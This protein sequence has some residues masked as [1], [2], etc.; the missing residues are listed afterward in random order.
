MNPTAADV[1]AT[2]EYSMDKWQMNQIPWALW[3]CAGGLVICLHADSRGGNGAALAFFYIAL[4]GLAFAGWAGTTLIDRSGYPYYVTLP[5]VIIIAIVIAAFIS[6]FGSNRGYPAYGRLWWSQL[7][8]PPLNVF[9][10]MLLYLGAGWIAFALYRHTY[11]GRPIIMLTPAGI[12]FH[13]AWLQNVFI[14][15]Q[16]VQGVGALEDENPGRAPTIYPH[17]I[18]VSVT[19]DSY[20]NYILPKRSFLSPPGSE[21]MFRPKGPLMQMVLA[22]PELIVDFEDF[23][24][25][26]EAR[27]KAFRDQARADAP[28]E[29]PPGMP[30]IFGRWS[31]DVPWWRAILF[32]MPLLGIAAVVLNAIR[33]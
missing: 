7:V 8:N 25:P 27:W 15:W 28:S 10:W 30:V 4:L 6:L 1:S 33:L 17:T 18:A 13:R 2:V 3:F 26:I 14:P 31:M 11:P 32:L 19:N 9:G 29:R 12:S 16:D 20:E 23:R 21:A 22:S 24:G 5:V